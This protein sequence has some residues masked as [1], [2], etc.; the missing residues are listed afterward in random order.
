VLG[1]YPFHDGKNFILGVY[2]NSPAHE[3]AVTKQIPFILMA[4]V[5]FKSW[6]NTVIETQTVDYGEA[7]TAPADHP[8]R[9]GYTFSGWDKAFDSVTSDLTVTA[10]Y[11]LNDDTTII[12]DRPGDYS[13]GNGEVTGDMYIYCD[14]VHIDNLVLHGNLY[15]AG[16]NIYIWGLYADGDVELNSTGYVTVWGGYSTSGYKNYGG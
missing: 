12:I 4:D 1:G 3:Y 6:D 7:A 11:T 15:A 14:D 16:K 10:Q 2:E 5:I 9:A 13:F 8:T